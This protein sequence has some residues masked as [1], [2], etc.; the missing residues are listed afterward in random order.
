[1]ALT[2]VNLIKQRL[3]DWGAALPVDMPPDPHSNHAIA[4]SDCGVLKK[5][6]LYRIK[7]LLDET[8]RMSR[9]HCLRNPSYQCDLK[10]N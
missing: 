7:V 5:E 9:K 3:R 6:T 8:N 10:Y 4:S 2:K 1:M